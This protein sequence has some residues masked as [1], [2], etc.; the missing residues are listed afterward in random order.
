MSKLYILHTIWHIYLQHSKYI[1][2]HLHKISIESYYIVSV[3]C[4]VDYV[5]CIEICKSVFFLRE[6]VLRQDL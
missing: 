4:S 1:I 2:L 6:Y 3:S 5:L